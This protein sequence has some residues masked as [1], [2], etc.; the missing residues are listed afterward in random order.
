MAFTKRAQSYI[1]IKVDLSVIENDDLLLSSNILRY[2][3]KS[4]RPSLET[5][6]VEMLCLTNSGNWV[7]ILAIF[8]M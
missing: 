1:C 7:T 2:C 5:A 4:F 6:L 8:V 3:S